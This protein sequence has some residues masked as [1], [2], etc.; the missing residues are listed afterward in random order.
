VVLNTTPAFADF[1]MNLS[2]GSPTSQTVTAGQAASFSLSMAALGTFS[3]N[4]NVSCAI[5]PT[6]TLGPTCSLSQSSVQVSGTTGQTITVTVGTTAPSTTGMLAPIGL[7]RSVPP[8]GWI[9][10]CTVLIGFGGLALRSG[11][12]APILLTPVVL[13]AMVI[14]TSCGGTGSSS[15]SHNTQQGTPQGTYTATVTAT[16][17]ALSHTLALKV[18]VQ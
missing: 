9:L 1:S 15:S 14:W 11:K 18:I 6:A 10:I 5:A 3:G 17:S 2:S 13:L 8:C 4:V 7:P 16:S 12:R